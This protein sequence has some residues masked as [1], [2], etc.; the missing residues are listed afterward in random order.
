MRREG[1]VANGGVVGEGSEAARGD[2]LPLVFPTPLPL[3]EPVPDLGGDAAS[4]PLENTKAIN[5]VRL[6]GMSEM[7]SI[8]LF[9]FE[10]PR[11]RGKKGQ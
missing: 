2:I 8:P 10:V 4:V 6:C 1:K 9:L 7:E 3:A 11:W 5:R